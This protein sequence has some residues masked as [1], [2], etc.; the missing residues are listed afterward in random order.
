MKRSLFLSLLLSIA[1]IP[2]AQAQRGFAGGGGFRGGSGGVARGGPVAA[3][4]AGFR[5][6][7]AMGGRVMAPPGRVFVPGGARRFNRGVVVAPGGHQVFSFNFRQQH[8]NIFFSRNCFTFGCRHHFFN[9]GL[10]FGNPFLASPFFGYGYIPGFDYGYGYGSPYY[11]YG[12]QQQQPV[13]VQSDNGGNAQLAVEVQRLSDEISDLRGEQAMQRMQAAR[14]QQV[15]GTS[16]SV[17]NP[18]VSTT[19]VFHDGRRVTAQNYAITGQTLWILN[20]HTSKKFSLS[21]VDR[22]ATEQVN[23]ANGVD[24]HLPEPKH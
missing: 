11:D 8:R 10:F 19:F 4:R 22:A 3:P 18:A 13:V 9:N 6:G 2:S 1:L 21:D 24:L 12:Y 17:V 23:S 7:P 5:G 15:P 14:Q 16:M 20:E